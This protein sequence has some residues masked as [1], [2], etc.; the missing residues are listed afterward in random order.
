MWT[1]FSSVYT[2]QCTFNIIY[3]HVYLIKSIEMYGI[4]LEV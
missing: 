2:V 3:D 1:Y 4:D